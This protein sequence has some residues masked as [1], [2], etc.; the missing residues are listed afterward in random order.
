M[1]KKSEFAA[2]PPKAKRPAW[3]LAIDKVNDGPLFRLA[4]Y[5]EIYCN[6]D[7]PIAKTD[8][9]YVSSDG[10]VYLNPY[11]QASV[12]EWEYII[13]HCL[14]HL[15]FGHFQKDRLQDPAW[16]AACDMMVT[17]FLKDSHIGTPPPEFRRELPFPVKDEEQ[18]WQ[19]LLE[20]PLPSETFSTMTNG[21]PDMIWKKT[22]I[23]LDYTE[24]FAES[25]QQSVKDSLRIAKGL[26]PERNDYEYNR[27]K[28]EQAREWFLS[29]FPLLGAVAAAFR[30]VDDPDAVRRMDIPV[31]AVSA[32]LGEIYI[33]PRCR[34]NLEEW[35]FVLAHEFLHAALRHDVRCEDR[36]PE[37]WNVACDYVVNAWLVEMKIGT[38]PE[39]VLLDE[40]FSGMAVESV[41]DFICEDMRRYRSVHAG[42]ILY[43][44]TGWWDSLDGSRTDALYRSALQ[45][46]L[47]YQETHGRGYLPAGLVEEIRAISRPPIRWDVELAKWFDE[48][49]VPVEKHRTYAR[50][51]RRQSSTPDIP[52]PAWHTEEQTVQQRIFGVLLDTSGSMD[53]GLLAAALGSI[54][55]YSEARDVHHVR[56]V[57]CDAMAYD[58]GI[59]APEEIAGAVQVRGRGGTKLQPGIDL[60]DRDDR[61]PKDAP[62]LIITD[63][64]CDR[65]NLRGRKHAYLLP[66]GR[67]LPFTP[68]GP[69]FKLK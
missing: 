19:R 59:M 48:Q 32:Q 47:A 26:P 50:L 42:D 56:V 25:L 18:T 61:F 69:V 27:E 21:R 33:N 8:W 60:L 5:V 49:F 40:R 12:G 68:K 54:A 7:Y 57:F 23:R 17:K 29:S 9:A 10:S 52:R 66:W 38:A 37:L 15:G 31:A 2:K 34:L 11:C 36:D 62:L 53:R 41:Y 13:S 30:I 65:L 20:T 67:R 51:S 46:G 55:S 22:T 64:A 28:Y 35:K 58:Q 44:D 45:Q 6:H 16:V 1:G 14:L 4:Y 43:G 63:G 3:K 39:F 24:V